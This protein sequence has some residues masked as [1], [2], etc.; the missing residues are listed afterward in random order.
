MPKLSSSILCY[1]VFQSFP[2]FHYYHEQSNEHLCAFSSLLRC[3]YLGFHKWDQRVSTFL[4]YVFPKC[5]SKKKPNWF[6]RLM[7]YLV[8]NSFNKIYWTSTLCRHYLDAVNI[9]KKGG[10]EASFP[11]SR[12]QERSPSVPRTKPSLTELWWHL[13]V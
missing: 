5:S 11:S 12:L 4:S 6:Q 2:V 10:L 9:V 8:I 1:W 3:I 7:C 13:G